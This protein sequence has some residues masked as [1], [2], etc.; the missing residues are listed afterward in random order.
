MDMRMAM[1]RC[2][3]ER[4]KDV[5]RAHHLYQANGDHSDDTFHLQRSQ[6]LRV[7]LHP[8]GGAAIGSGQL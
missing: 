5:Q 1:S 7:L 2:F 6:Q 3:D 8:S 4:D